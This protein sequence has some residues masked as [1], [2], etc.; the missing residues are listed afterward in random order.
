MQF[1]VKKC[2][3]QN[4]NLSFKRPTKLCEHTFVIHI[5]CGDWDGAIYKLGSLKILNCTQI[6]IMITFT[7]WVNFG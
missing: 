7:K 4:C 6:V 3:S 2:L 1:Q 5:F